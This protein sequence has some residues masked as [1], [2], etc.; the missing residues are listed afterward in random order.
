MT[1]DVTRDGE[2]PY[3][4]YIQ[5]FFA[6][7]SRVYDLFARP[8]A[9]AYWAA[10]RRAGAG[11]GRA[12]LDICTGTGE[13]ALRCARLGADVTAIDVTASMLQRAM[14]KTRGL[15]IR[16][17]LMDARHLEFPDGAFDVAVLSFAV[18]DMPRV[19]RVAALREAAR[20]AR[21]AVV[22]LDYDFPRREPWRAMVVGLVRLYETAY[23]P[24]FA[25]QGLAPVLAEAGLE[26]AAVSSPLP[27]FCAIHV[28]RRGAPAPG[29]HGC[30]RLE[31]S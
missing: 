26:I 9:F 11:P 3:V 25:R 27:G 15:P 19:A 31:R 17:H 8:I 5:H 20:V 2:D 24:D 10:A 18:H 1:P 29:P 21:E 13:M 12:V 16:F 23:L 22:I 30:V 14:A 28:V 6:R 7:W 4:S